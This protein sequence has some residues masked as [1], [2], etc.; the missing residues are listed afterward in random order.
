[1]SHSACRTPDRAP[2]GGIAH[3][4]T[5]QPKDNQGTCHGRRLSL[6]DETH[7]QNWGP[8]QDSG[9]SPSW[10]SGPQ[11]P[12]AGLT[13]SPDCGPGGRLPREGPS[14]PV[15]APFPAHP[16]Q[17]SGN[18]RDARRLP[19]GAVRWLNSIPLNSRPPSTSEHDLTWNQDL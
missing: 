4:D 14:P 18:V 19:A 13:E 15:P 3:P 9:F 11:G 1:M 6:C 7:V 17:S 10:S 2:S 8:E 12:Q 16:C 5:G